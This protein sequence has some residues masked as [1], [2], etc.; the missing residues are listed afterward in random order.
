MSYGS[1]NNPPIM[2]SQQ[3]DLIQYGKLILSLG[4]L[5]KDTQTVVAN[6]QHA[7]DILDSS[8]TA[9]LKQIVIYALSKPGLRGKAIDEILGMM[10]FKVVDILEECE[11]CV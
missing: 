5:T 9:E 8:Y 4:S 1:Q 3:D 11:R 6:L 2:H 10:N 7:L